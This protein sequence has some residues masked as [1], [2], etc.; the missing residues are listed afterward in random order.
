MFLSRIWSDEVLT[1]CYLVNCMPSIVL[2]DQIP[3]RVL[4]PNRSL[5]ILPPR[6]FGCMCYVHALNLG[7]DQFD[8]WV[9]KCFF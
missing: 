9:I 1:A 2:G 4:V 8:P 6:V 5:Y 7:H 3:H